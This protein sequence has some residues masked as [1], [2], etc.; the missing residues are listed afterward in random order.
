MTTR[1]QRYAIGQTVFNSLLTYMQTSNQRLLE[2]TNKL[3]VMD[4]NVGNKIITVFRDSRPQEVRLL[5]S[6]T[7]KLGRCHCVFKKFTH[8]QFSNSINAEY[9]YIISIFICLKK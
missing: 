1:P 8:L 2:E 3:T 6:S 5:V 9:Q 7:H 4:T